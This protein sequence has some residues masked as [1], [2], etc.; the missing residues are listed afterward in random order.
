LRGL[1]WRRVASPK[2]IVARL[3]RGTH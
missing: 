1:A 2:W 3:P